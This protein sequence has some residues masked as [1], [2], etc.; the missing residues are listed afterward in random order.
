MKKFY[1]QPE[2]FETSFDEKGNGFKNVLYRKTT[3]KDVAIKICELIKVGK[4]EYQIMEEKFRRL[5]FVKHGN[6]VQF[7]GW[8]NWIE[9]NV[10]VVELMRISLLSGRIFLLFSGIFF[11]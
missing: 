7:L 9:K 11:N 1:I 6:I 5:S 8:T 2:E 3:K 4:D 10:I